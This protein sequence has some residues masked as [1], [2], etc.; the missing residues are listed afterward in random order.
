MMRQGLV[1]GALLLA[2]SGCLKASHSCEDDNTCGGPSPTGGAA[3]GGTQGASGSAADG[4]MSAAGSG[5]EAATGGGG[6]G[7]TGGSETGGEPPTTGGAGATSNTGGAAGATVGV[8]GRAGA[9]GS[10]EG[11]QGG[12]AGGAGANGGA[13]GAAPGCDP[14]QSPADDACVVS[15]EVGIFVSPDGDDGTGEG[16]RA[17]PYATLGKGIE[18]AAAAGK[19]V[20]ACA[21]SEAYTETLG[22]DADASGVEL[23]GGFDCASWEYST[24]QRA[25]LE[26]GPT[27]VTINGA[28]GMEWHDFE[29]EAA[30]A[31]EPGQSSVGMFVVGAEMVLER[32]AL[33]AGQGS[34][35]AAGSLTPFTGYPTASELEGGD[36]TESTPGI[37]CRST[38]LSC[39]A[40]G[41]P[42]EGG[43]GGRADDNGDDGID[44][45]PDTLPGGDGG[46]VEEC[47]SDTG[48][49]SGATPTT[50]N[51]GR[52]ATALGTLSASGWEPAPGNDGQPGEPGQGGGGGASV[53]NAGGG[54]GGGCGGCGGNG[55]L[56][57]SG[58]GASI[59][60][61]MVGA[62]VELV[63]CTLTTSDAGDGGA[64][65]AGEA[66]QDGGTRGT[67]AGNACNGGRGG[68]G[69]DGGA[70]GGGAGGISVGI[71]Y[72]GT[73]PT[74]DAATTAAITVGME[75]Q[76]GEAV[77]SGKPNTAGRVGVSLTVLNVQ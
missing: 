72:T 12:S 21:T 71:V 18:E 34:D 57:G 28:T 40:G 43:D 6:G 37:G 76:G 62:Q 25:R 47:L 27:A 42:G 46:T 54:G 41:A 75:G 77:S 4:G 8:G 39:P 23:W 56:A 65:V 68:A 24:T 66:G 74:R 60:L 49:H 70:S 31:T 13:G 16:T 45:K 73:E 55:A 44:G 63:G 64:G 9:A 7:P 58:G 69:Q 30:A 20:Y 50:T 2:L 11:G 53:D 48:G 26:G 67:G 32:V 52:G 17:A 19:R 36:G 10:G 59:A 51:D 38:T 61:L 29:I 5:G 14:T 3:T 33:I 15:D 22:L 1:A 35:G